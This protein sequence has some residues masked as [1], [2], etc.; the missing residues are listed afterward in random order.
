MER[1]TDGDQRA[2]AWGCPVLEHVTRATSTA[3]EYAVPRLVGHG[4]RSRSVNPTTKEYPA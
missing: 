3:A 2:V 4:V 1:R